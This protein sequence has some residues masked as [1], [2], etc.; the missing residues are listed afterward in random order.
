[1][2][3]NE[4]LNFHASPSNNAYLINNT[5][6]E[7]TSQHRDLGVIFS[8]N[9]S[10]TFHLNFV[11]SKAFKVLSFLCHSISVFHS[12]KT[13][14]ILYL[15]HVRSQIAYCSHIWRNKFNA[16]QQ[17][18]FSM[19]TLLT[20]NKRLVTLNLLPIYPSGWSSDIL[21]FITYIKNPHA[22]L[23]QHLSVHSIHHFKYQIFPF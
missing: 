23:L 22:T 12:P 17:S 15:T 21:L 9:P 8:D 3:L 1:M 5:P 4:G 2:A 19:I 6:I 7:C 14:L 20:I 10:W 18:S 16:K 11:I 13:K